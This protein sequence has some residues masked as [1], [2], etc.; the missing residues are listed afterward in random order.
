[1]LLKKTQSLV[2]IDKTVLA[3]FVADVDNFE[4][5]RDLKNYCITSLKDD[6]YSFGNVSMGALQCYNKSNNKKINRL[7]LNRIQMIS[8]FVGALTAKAQEFFGSFTTIVGMTES[9]D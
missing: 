9:I 4:G 3:T 6:G 8:K 5:M 7:D 1:M 2:D